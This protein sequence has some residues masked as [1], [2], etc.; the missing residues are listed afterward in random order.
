M[1]RGLRIISALWFLALV[2]Y[3][4]RVAMGF[5]GPSIM[6][7]L[8]MTP[9]EFGIIL[10]SFGIGYLLAQ[11]PGG[12]LADRWGARMLL[13]VG[14]V[15]WAIFTGM[16]GLVSSLAAFVAV[17]I[18]FGFSEGLSNTSVYKALGDHFPASRRARVLG[19][20]STAIPLAPAFAGA[21]IGALVLR[22]G[23]QMMFFI[24]I[25][26]SLLAAL[27]CYL[28][29]PAGHA[30]RVSASRV[31]TPGSDSF[32]DVL[33]RPSVWILS[34]A[35]FAWNMPYW[36]FLGW[37]P[38]YLAI[39]H[40]IDL[41]AVGALGSLIYI[42]AF[43]GLLIG[44]WLGSSILER[45]CPELVVAC[46]AG[47]AICLVIAYRGGTLGLAVAG[48]S[49]AAFFLFGTSG[50][51]G[52]VAL[53]L[54]PERQRGVFVGIYNTAGHAGGALA[55]AVIGWLVGAT[56]SFAAGFL[57]MIAGLAVAAVC[58]LG[59][60]STGGGA[61]D[62]PSVPPQAMRNDPE[63]DADIGVTS[64]SSARNA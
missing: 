48:L 37:M 25:I 63:R 42:F 14:P 1:S 4:E 41:K 54:A 12:L 31:G 58:F 10:S 28:L 44:G 8:H 27:G 3:L 32:R 61:Q 30:P 35:C 55:P 53:D 13:V 22:Y 2:N 47:A 59:L 50:P 33:K 52:K 21:A 6:K 49:G 64:L 43:I 40:H 7:S 23:W 29:L 51:V 15:L 57:F 5:A 16:T 46:F 26:P 20:C 18:C 60:A 9:G 17:R 36:G 62:N 39:A 56:G 24:M 19:I 11:V 38:S 45:R 34:L